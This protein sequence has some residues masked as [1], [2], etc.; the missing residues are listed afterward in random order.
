[1]ENNYTAPKK[2]PGC[3]GP[4]FKYI[5]VSHNTYHLECGYTS[6]VTGDIV[7]DGIT[8]KNVEIP[9]KKLPCGYKISFS[10]LVP[11]QSDDIDI[12]NQMIHSVS[13]YRDREITFDKPDE[14]WEESSDDDIY[15]ENEYEDEENE[16]MF[17][18]EFEESE[19]SDDEISISS[20]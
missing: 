13:K 8:H 12:Q 17:Q 9:S 7:K 2:C 20:K 4:I 5:N 1:M 10:E 11:V 6:F 16:E 3:G 18:D 19:Q 14:I 15:D